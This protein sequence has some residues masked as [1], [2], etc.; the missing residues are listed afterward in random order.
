MTD[1]DKILYLIAANAEDN[2]KGEKHVYIPQCKFD[3]LTDEI[4]RLFD[5]SKAKRT[6]CLHNR[7]CNW[8]DGKGGCRNKKTCD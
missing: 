3:N 2:F 5:V 4:L 1:K 6:V 8:D 7:H